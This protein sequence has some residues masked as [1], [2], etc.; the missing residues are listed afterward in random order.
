[1]STMRNPTFWNQAGVSAHFCIGK[2]GSI[3]QLV[4]IFNTAYHAGRLGPVSWR[5]YETML[6]ETGSSNPNTYTIGVEHEGFTGQPWTPQMYDADVQLKQWCIEACA[7]A[8]HDLMRFG[9]D[10]LAGHFMFDGRDRANCPGHTWP[11]TQLYADL[12]PRKEEEDF[13]MANPVW[14]V[15]KDR[16][17][18]VTYRTY[19]C[20]ATPTGLKKD[21][22][23]SLEQEKALKAAG[24][25]YGVPMPMSLDELKQFAGS[26]EADAP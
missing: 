3:A 26:P 8:G 25:I 11:R 7:E 24:M 2:D 17:E 22:V 5:Y 23:E 19:L 20:F 15:W 4:N 21:F 9:L 10:S 13:V 16:P 12:Q 18:S 14:S 1:M 6:T